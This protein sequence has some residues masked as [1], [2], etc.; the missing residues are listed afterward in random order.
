MITHYQ[1]QI[2]KRRRNDYLLPNTK[3]QVE[4]ENSLV[5]ESFGAH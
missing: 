3:S 5:E 1:T 2:D 4:E